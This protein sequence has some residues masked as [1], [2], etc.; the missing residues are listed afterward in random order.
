MKQ[1]EVPVLIVGG[2]VAGLSCSM[3]LAKL[4]VES[5]LVTYYPGTSPQ[6]KAHIINQRTM[7]IF[8]E[9]GVAEA[10][11][12]V[13]TPPELMRYAGWYAGLGGGSP[14]HGREIGRVEAWGGGFTDPDYIAASACRPANYPQMY[15]EPI[16][17]AHAEKLTPGG[18]LYFHEFLDFCQDRDGVTAR[19]R[20]RGSGEEFLVRAKYLLAAD[21]GK[22]IGK[23]VGIAMIGGDKTM[24]MTSVHFAA[25]LS[26][27]ATGTDVLTRFLINPDFGGS[28]ASGALLPEGPTNWGNKSEEWVYHSRYTISQ[29]GPIDHAKVLERMHTVLGIED[30]KLDVHHISEWTMGGFLAER[31]RAGKVFLVGD[32]CKTHPPTGGLGMNSA[33]QDAYNL[34]WKLA[35]VLRGKA[36]DGLLDTY[37]EERR[38]V[39]KRNVELAMAN[40]MQHFLID[41][42]IGLSDDDS[43]EENWEKMR[44]IWDDTPASEPLREAVADAIA[45]QR[46][47]FR[48]HNVE[49]GYTYAHGAIVDDGSVERPPL[50]PVLIYEPSTKPG[51]PLPHA[52][53][54]RLGRMMPIGS[55]VEGGSFV[56]LAGEDG[57]AW[58]DAARRVAA[59][60]GIP[61][62]ALRIGLKKG[63][64]IDM[65]G[66]WLKHRGINPDG[67]V[68]IRPDRYVA[69]RSASR[70]ADPAATLS[71]V[72]DTILGLSAKAFSGEGP[73]QGCAT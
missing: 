67:A 59:A 23:Q 5:L 46:I 45:M 64:Y 38:P 6:P 69:F 12:K 15:L 11:Y 9:L 17:K 47:G 2:G 57:H 30:L 24:R 61:L 4:G 41:E 51:H 60:L 66:A 65:R 27:W 10:V 22:T 70:S 72:F 26:P 28:W 43:P 25:D 18:L 36:G 34:C 63:D 8:T 48:H 53:V 35:L 56:L 7:E 19:V 62:Q 68:L 13:S 54:G 55:F 42:A 52:M 49:F 73:L 20:N 50:D 33:V 37:E 14:Y 21:G 71:D 58:V 31:Y 3:V 40:A 39:A 44:M 16:L 29:T 1:I 32:A